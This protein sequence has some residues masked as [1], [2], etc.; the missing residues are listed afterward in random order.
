MDA[1]QKWG[2]VWPACEWTRAHSCSVL[3]ASIRHQHG[4][5][6]SRLPAAVALQECE[7]SAAMAPWTLLR[8]TAHPK[9]IAKTPLPPPTHPEYCHLFSSRQATQTN[10]SEYTWNLM[11]SA[12][13]PLQPF[14]ANST[15]LESGDFYNKELL[16]LIITTQ[17][18]QT[19]NS[20]QRIRAPW[21]ERIP[22]KC[23]ISKNSHW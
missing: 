4:P 8:S 20:I 12:R 22:G 19:L 18:A 7:E 1:S 10:N 23:T 11:S 16:D 2:M 9:T 21:H 13:R 6:L 3:L 17:S 5:G 15:W 14:Q